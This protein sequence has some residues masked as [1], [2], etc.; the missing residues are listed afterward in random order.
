MNIEITG[1][2]FSN[3]GAQLMLATVC[4]RLRNAMPKVRL[5]IPSGTSSAVERSQ[6]GLSE[7]V[8]PLKNRRFRI[9][10]RWNKCRE[11]LRTRGTE[12]KA[13]WTPAGS[14]GLMHES[15]LDGI[16]DISGYAFG[17]KWPANK[18]QR[19]SLPAAELQ[20]RGKPVVM[21][22]Q[23]LGPF[24]NPGQ[25]EAF[26]ELASHVNLIYARDQ[27]SYDF[28]RPFSSMRQLRL[29]PDITIEMPPKP[30]KRIAERYACIVPNS[31]LL[32]ANPQRQDWSNSYLDR[33]VAS[34]RQCQ[35]HGLDVAIVQ[36]EFNDGDSKL[37]AELCRQVNCPPSHIV[38]E[39]NPQVLKWI[40][41]GACL[42][43]GSRFHSLVS[44]LSMGV[45][46]IAL[47]W[48]HKY[49]A[50]LSDFAV[51]EM[52]HF[53]TSPLGHLLGL[54]DSSIE[55]HAIL[56]GRILDRK[57]LLEIQIQD[58]W[59]EVF[60]Q[61]GVPMTLHDAKKKCTAPAPVAA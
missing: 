34:Y 55:N 19:L 57:K 24:T 10:N 5:T 53:A 29:A 46:A 56:S 27:E 59:F 51:P 6:F 13:K 38:T 9:P 28:A 16:V 39:H 17:D 12:M 32:E 8:R 11:L 35:K 3:K 42:V 1:A 41:G 50:L 31:K 4:H 58:M 60:G 47:G 44:A 49:D 40:L 2:N 15:R 14:F 52:I 45:P 37:V 20:R 43:I 7:T 61:L 21:L 18:A 23:M 54:I 48:A 25:A 22:P 26:Q 30:G 36:H 33:L